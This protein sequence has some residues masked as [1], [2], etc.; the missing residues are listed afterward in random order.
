M[1]P[2]MTFLLTQYKGTKMK[3]I[4]TPLVLA[5]VIFAAS[6]P[7]H[8]GPHHDNADGHHKA[9][10]GHHP[11]MKGDSHASKAKSSHH[12]EMKGHE[13]GMGSM[14]G[15]AGK[16]EDVSRTIKVTA[17]D[18]MR[19]THEP[20]NVKDG[21][22]IKFVV[23]NS[24][25]IAHEFSIATKAEHIG[26]GKMMINNPGMHH[27]PGGNVISIKPGE[28]EELIWTFEHAREIEAACNIP[29]HYE[30]G[31]HSPVRIQGK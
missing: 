20:I 14:T 25:A 10:A 21:E 12:S 26:H 18:S 22:T 24:G 23:T 31:M 19:F 29:G 27:P 30:A 28:T 4:L 17:D 6:L 2:P 15:T 13:H 7:V 5:S 11:E 1:Y 8:A 3:K 16:A 9:K